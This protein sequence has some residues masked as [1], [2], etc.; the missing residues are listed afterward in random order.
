MFHAVSTDYIR[1]PFNYRQIYT[2]AN[3]GVGPEPT[4]QLERQAE[5]HILV[6]SVVFLGANGRDDELNEGQGEKCSRVS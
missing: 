2:A 5:P 3:E 6:H 1:K 4:L